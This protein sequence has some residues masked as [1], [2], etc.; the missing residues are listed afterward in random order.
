VHTAFWSSV[1]GLLLWSLS[2]QAIL[3]IEI[4][5]SLDVGM[6]IAIVPF[7]FEGA[8]RPP[9]DVSAVVEN[10]LVNLSGH[11]HGISKHDFV[12]QP[13][14]DK[15]VVYKDWRIAKAEALVIGKLRRLGA[16]QY[17]AEFRLYDVFNEKLL[18][19]NQ[20]DINGA[21]LR[22]LAHQI[23]DIIYEKL[24]GERGVFNTR[25]AYIT[26]EGGQRSVV[27]KLYVADADGFNPREMLKSH[28]PLLSLAWSPDGT[29]LA[30]TSFEQRR[31]TLYVQNVQDGTRTLLAEFPGRNSA[32]AWSPDGTRMALTL[33][34]DDIADI[35]VMRLADRSLQR[36]TSNPAIDTEPAWSPDGQHIVFT[37]D[38]SGKPQIYRVS[39]Q[40]GAA[41]RVTYEGDYNARASY[42]P[43]GKTLAL[44]T[45]AEGSYRIAVLDLKTS[46][47][48]VLT[49]T[50]LDESPSF[51][52]N[53][54][55]ILYSTTVQGRGVLAWVSSDGKVHT[56]STPQEG[57]VREPAWSPFSR[58]P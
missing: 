42:S 23:S 48:Q 43:D 31:A 13:H 56:H 28:E 12:S 54:R 2:A 52:P 26:K 5:Q 38:R 50:S 18:V 30:Y 4:T 25:I 8:G 7:S 22:T 10:D 41:E 19:A 29:R 58:K 51:A 9:V 6:P 47:L 17:R 39:A 40:G 33:S 11:F 3:T 53:G 45:R 49:D 37:S 57:D 34:K 44:V 1:A 55:M 20:L 27:F 46:A 14:D 32:P 35:Y 36:L 15:D 21:G 24:T 16:D